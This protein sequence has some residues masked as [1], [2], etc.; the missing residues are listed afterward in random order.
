MPELGVNGEAESL[1]AVVALN[2]VRSSRPDMYKQAEDY[3]RDSQVFLEIS[4]ISSSFSLVSSDNCVLD[5]ASDERKTRIPFQ[6]WCDSQ[7]A[8]HPDKDLEFSPTSACT[9][10]LPSP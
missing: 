7:C 1:L 4:N 5:C 10:P 2:V 9:K 6:H 8:H 3:S